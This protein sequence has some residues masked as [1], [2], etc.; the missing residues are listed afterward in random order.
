MNTW[1]VHKKKGDIIGKETID[2]WKSHAICFWLKKCKKK[3]IIVKN[4]S[5]WNWNVIVIMY[6]SYVN[7][8]NIKV[9]LKKSK[10]K[11]FLSKWFEMF[12]HW[13]VQELL[14]FHK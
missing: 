10:T 6:I 1:M 9:L 12:E 7:S 2:L 8:W 4:C 14:F 11:F 5:N 3:K 13:V